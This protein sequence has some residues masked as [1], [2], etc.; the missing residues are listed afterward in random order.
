MKEPLSSAVE[1]GAGVRGILAEQR[2]SL[3]LSHTTRTSSSID[4]PARRGHGRRRRRA[5]ID[6]RR[7]PLTIT[8]PP[9]YP[10]DLQ[11]IIEEDSHHE[12][13]VHGN[14]DDDISGMHP[15]EHSDRRIIH[16]D[17][18]DG[19]NAVSQGMKEFVPP[20]VRMEFETYDDAYNY[21]N[22]YAKENGFRVRV[23]NYWFKRHSKEKYGA[24]LCCSS[25]G[26]KR[27]KDAHCL[28]EETRTGC[29]AMIRMRIVESK[30]CRLLE[31]VLEHNHLLGLKPHKSAKKL[32]I[33][34]KKKLQP[35]A[36]TE[37]QKLKIFRPLVIDAGGSVPREFKSSSVQS[38]LLG[39]KKGDALAI[40]NNFCCMQLT[41]PNF[42]YLMDFGKEFKEM[43]F[44]SMLDPWLHVV[45]S[46]MS[47]SL[48]IHT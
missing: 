6:K 5:V 41:N 12:K 30:R 46:V 20:A 4:A 10:Q 22:C 9:I 39:F 18:L 13:E 23:K 15:V 8:R 27:I 14:D 48:A 26:F 43:S 1:D 19:E 16:G 21:Y 7:S 35:N 24:V 25:Q 3:R 17:R 34:T 2:S 44:G 47:F 32:D 45:T 38:N 31:V 40:Y 33:G 37:V 42:F 36:C 29:P 11:F 28:R